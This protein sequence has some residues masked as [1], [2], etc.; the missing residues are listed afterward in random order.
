M[1]VGFH[2]VNKVTIKSL[3]K[4]TLSQTLWFPTHNV[5]SNVSVFL[6][7]IGRIGPTPLLSLSTGTMVELRFITEHDTTPL[8]TN[9]RLP[10]TAPLQAFSPLML[11]AVYALDGGCLI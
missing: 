8:I 2:Y 10:V 7:N 11:L 6:H 5:R 9:T 4:V 3:P 1:V